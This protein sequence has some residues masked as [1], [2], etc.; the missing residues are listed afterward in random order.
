MINVSNA[1]KEAM[2]KPMKELDGYINVP[3]EEAINGSNNLISIKIS[4]DSCFV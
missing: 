2:K 1:F 3:N 4:C